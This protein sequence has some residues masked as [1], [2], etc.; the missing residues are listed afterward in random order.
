MACISGPAMVSYGDKHLG[1]ATEVR[2]H[3]RAPKYHHA[4]RRYWRMKN[5]RRNSWLTKP[6]SVTLEFKTAPIG[7]ALHDALEGELL[8]VRCF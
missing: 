7:I 8:R 3:E 2:A 6:R 5:S 1:I 4:R